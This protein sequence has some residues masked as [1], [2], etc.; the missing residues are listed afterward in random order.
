MAAGP[1]STLQCWTLGPPPS[2]PPGNWD[3]PPVGEVF[4]MKVKLDTTTLV[5]TSKD[6]IMG[7]IP[8]PPSPP[9]QPVK[10]L[11][12]WHKTL[13]AVKLEQSIGK[14]EENVMKKKHGQTSAIK[15]YKKFWDSF[16]IFAQTYSCYRFTPL[17]FSCLFFV[18]LMSRSPERKPI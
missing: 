6:P 15:N 16:Q 17:A 7:T 2:P 10:K 18:L 8:V 5:L 1:V 3:E 13:G 12:R 14:K 4:N 9:L 11:K